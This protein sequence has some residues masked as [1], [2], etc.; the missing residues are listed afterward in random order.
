[1]TNFPPTSY[2]ANGTEPVLSA[3][4][5][6]GWTFDYWSGNLP[7]GA[8]PNN[9]EL[10][11]LMDKD[12][13]IT[14]HF[15]MQIRTLT[16][17]IMG[18]GA[19]TPAGASD[20]G[21]EYDYAEGTQ[22]WLDAAPGMNGWAFSNWSGD[23]GSAD[24][25]S[26]NFFVTMNQDRTVVATYVAAD[27]SLTLAYTG[28]G[29]TWPEPGTYGF[30]D[31]APVEVVA[32]IASG[33]DAFDH[34]EGGPE[35]SDIYD[36]GQRFNI[37]SDM[38]MTAVFTPGDYTLTTT[39]TGGGSAEYVSHPAGV[40]Q[41][42]AG[43]NAHIEVRPWHE[44]YWGGYSGDITTFDYIANVLMDGDKNVIITLGTSGYE[45]VVNQTGGGITH[46]SGAWRFV[47]GATPTIHAIDNSSS[48]FTNWSGELPPDVDPT[49]RDPVILM[50][51]HRTVFANF[52]QADWYLYIQASGNGTTDPAP[53]LYWFVEGT[54]FE[55]TATPGM[56]TLFL[57]WQGD[58]PEGQ[59]PASPTI[60]G[61]M[62]QNREL[63]AV[64]VPITVAVPDLSGMTQTEAESVLTLL[65]FVLGTVTQEYSQTMPAGQIISQAPVAETIVA[66][67]SAVSIVIS[68][69]PCYAS[70][71][72]LSGFTQE[73][74]ETALA[75][76]NLTLGTV[77][78]ENSEFV[79]EGQVI[80]QQPVY[81]LL[82]TCG[83]SVNIVISLGI[84]IE[85]SEE[86]PHTADQDNNNVIS[87]S[88]L[89]RVIQFFNSTGLHCQAGTEDGYAPGQGDQTCAAHDSDY[90][91]QDWLITLSELLRIIQFFNSGGYYSC[92]G[93]GT[94]DGFCPGIG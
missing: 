70:V 52:E 1:L 25:S 8:D 27:W 16:I 84:G 11:V 23:I 22:V 60:S 78:E 82:V 31:G 7:S 28:N 34:W 89:L 81:G 14:A 92:P 65:G 32:N 13:N 74:A 79:P 47:A 24:P 85:G 15:I 37:H 53:D 21:L 71:P 20:P 88:E 56:D 94:E 17:I 76:A 26:R 58:V 48:L 54:P 61:T 19:T 9:P 46:P 87:L 36:Q 50:D 72:N 10:P 69:G 40:Y 38:A 64:F 59:D 6:N 43:R 30:L 80:R 57:H 62:T 75:A 44:T 86:G 51:Q 41:Y 90:N 29:S 66:Y 45:L 39:V 12:R 83:S 67:G 4:P 73:E 77:G 3:H 5:Q 91:P 35:G 2:F 33:N 49:D 63:I 42:L 68:L 93:E 55:I 18:E